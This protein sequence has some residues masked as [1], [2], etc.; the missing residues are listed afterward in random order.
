[1][2]PWSPVSG[3]PMVPVPLPFDVG[4]PHAVDH[5]HRVGGRDRGERIG[6][7]PQ[8][9]PVELGGHRRRAL[10]SAGSARAWEG[11]L[12]RG[13]AP[14]VARGQH[15]TGRIGSGLVLAA[16]G[17]VHRILRWHVSS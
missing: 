9:D 5:D 1:M 11:Y 12:R 7:P 6:R 15:A 13:V 2:P 8:A 10:A 3:A 17:V 14:G 16:R 4:E